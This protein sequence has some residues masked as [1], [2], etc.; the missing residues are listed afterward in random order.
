MTLP[1]IILLYIKS[2]SSSFNFFKILFLRLNKAGADIPF[3]I[4]IERID[5]S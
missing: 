3:D 2:F 1:T 4:A 5:S